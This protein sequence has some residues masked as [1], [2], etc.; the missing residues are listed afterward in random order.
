M[1]LFRRH[2]KKS[3]ALEKLIVTVWKQDKPVK[4]A[5]DL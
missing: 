2:L 5:S 3:T 4:D 1:F